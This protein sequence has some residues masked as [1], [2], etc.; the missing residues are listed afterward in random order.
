MIAPMVNQIR[1][2]PGDTE[3]EVVAYCKA[4]NILVEAYSPLGTGL[5]F[6]VPQLK[7][8]SEKYGKTIAQLCIRWSLQMGFLPLPKSVTASRIKENADVFDFE[9]SAQDVQ[10]ISDLKGCCGYSA[11]PD[12]TNF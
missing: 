4:H 12:K 5:I 11:D 2:C 6:E 10:V 1:L 9:L 3:D 7:A 8:L